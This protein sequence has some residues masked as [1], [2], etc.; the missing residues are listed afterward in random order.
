MP[1]IDIFKKTYIGQVWCNNCS[2][3][4]EIQIPKGTTIAQFIEG[5]TGKCGICGCKT[6]IA[7]YKQI[8]EFKDNQPRPR[9]QL[10]PRRQA[11]VTEVK[12]RAPIP[13]PRP[14]TKP[15]N[16]RPLP[17]SATTIQD[18]EPGKIFKEDP[19]DFW[20]GRERPRRRQQQQQSQPQP[21]EYDETY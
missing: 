2:T 10:I 11:P 18:F 5:N 3:S 15:K 12:Q 19:V 6:L 20:T 4:Q 14:S 13:E 16:Y 21:E 9:M 1:L 17:K 7:D 8:D